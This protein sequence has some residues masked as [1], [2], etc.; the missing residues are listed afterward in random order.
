MGLQRLGVCSPL[1]R[2]VGIGGSGDSPHGESVV[3][4]V[5]A[6]SKIA[7]TLAGAPTVNAQVEEIKEGELWQR[8]FVHPEKMPLE[9]G[10]AVRVTSVPDAKEAEQVPGQ[11]IPEGDELTVPEPD[12]VTVSL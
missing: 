9:A 5:R 7:V 6:R 10:V 4:P 2:V 3:G 12:T 11:E 1:G 8:P